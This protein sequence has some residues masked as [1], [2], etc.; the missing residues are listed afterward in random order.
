[1]ER[2]IKQLVSS[3]TAY[4]I[5]VRMVNF[6]DISMSDIVS[7]AYN[8]LD[9]F[10]NFVYFMM[11]YTIDDDEL[12]STIVKIIGQRMLRSDYDLLCDELGKYLKAVHPLETKEA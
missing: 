6:H 12:L 8:D 11:S 10:K 1:M 4:Q 7:D 9:G 3:G 2:L 5:L